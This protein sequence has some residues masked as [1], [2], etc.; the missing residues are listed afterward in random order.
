MA[1]NTTKVGG[2]V[3]LRDGA[4]PSA[5]GLAAKATLEGHGF[6]VLIAPAS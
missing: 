5:T 6:T 1:T 3:D 2:T 4:Y